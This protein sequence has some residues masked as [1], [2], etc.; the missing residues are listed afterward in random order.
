[1]GK[2]VNY[3]ELIKVPFEVGLKSNFNLEGR[4]KYKLPILDTMVMLLEGQY[5]EDFE[6][7][8]FCFVHWTLDF[9]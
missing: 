4:I 6:Q 7:K 9:T 5:Q 3:L 1:M 2:E 8:H